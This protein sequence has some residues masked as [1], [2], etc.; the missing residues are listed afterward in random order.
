MLPALRAQQGRRASALALIHPVKP[1]RADQ[2]QE[3]LQHLSHE[4][5]AVMQSQ[6]LMWAIQWVMFGNHTRLLCTIHFDGTAGAV[7][8]DVATYE[9]EMCKCIWGHC[10]GYPESETRTIDDIVAY[11]AAGQVPIAAYFPGDSGKLS[12]RALASWS[13]AVPKPSVNPS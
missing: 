8:Q 2:L 5:I 12:S 4:D 1:G 6:R 11:L 10:I 13:S 7:L 3:A 9:P